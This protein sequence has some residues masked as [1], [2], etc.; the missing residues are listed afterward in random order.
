MDYQNGPRP[1]R[2]MHKAGDADGCTGEWACS[3]CGAK[4]DQLPFAPDPSR[5]GQLKCRDCHK[6][7]MGNFRRY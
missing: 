3:K 4:I 6:A 7:S 2:V 5:L 1:E